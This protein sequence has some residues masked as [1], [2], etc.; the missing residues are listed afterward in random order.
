MNNFVKTHSKM[1]I[2]PKKLI[3][4]AKE[5]NFCAVKYEKKIIHRTLF[6]IWSASRVEWQK[7][8]QF[9]SF[10]VRLPPTPFSRRVPLADWH[11]AISFA[12]MSFYCFTVFFFGYFLSNCLKPISNRVPSNTYMYLVWTL[13]HFSRP[14]LT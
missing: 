6:W 4:A 14:T 8:L 2:S 3:R 9:C 5:V 7:L 1:C 10:L 12:S 13:K 11:W